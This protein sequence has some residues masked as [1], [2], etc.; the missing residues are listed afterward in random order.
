MAAKEATNF[1]KELIVEE[2]VK[3]LYS[4]ISPKSW[5]MLMSIKEADPGT[6]YPI[7]QSFRL[8]APRQCSV[9][10]IYTT[11]QFSNIMFFVFPQEPLDRR[12]VAAVH[13]P[14]PGQRFQSA[15]CYSLG[16]STCSRNI[17]Y[18]TPR[19]TNTIRKLC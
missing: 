2:K 14:P 9:H 7:A 15:F 5:D 3:A 19:D 8:P 10:Q 11:G 6:L 16:F 12:F 1:R 17:E 13:R 18:S 4:T